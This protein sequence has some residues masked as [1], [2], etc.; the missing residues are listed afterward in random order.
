ME[1]DSS[2]EGNRG[3]RNTMWGCRNGRQ[4]VQGTPRL[5]MFEYAE[6][7]QATEEVGRCLTRVERSKM[8]R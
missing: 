6:K 8:A 4:L 2:I 1:H 5:E 3:E 7:P